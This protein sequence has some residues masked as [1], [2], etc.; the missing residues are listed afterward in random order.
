MHCGIEEKELSKLIDI[1]KGN[2][3]IEKK[4]DFFWDEE[5]EVWV[6]TSEEVPGLVLEHAS[7]DTLVERVKVVMEE[8]V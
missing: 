4:V 3:S 1:E 8:L 6:A 2:V 7:Y 5:V